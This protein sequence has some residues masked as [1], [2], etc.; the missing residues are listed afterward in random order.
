MGELNKRAHAIIL[1]NT[2]KVHVKIPQ[3]NNNN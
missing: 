2:L 1:S 3:T